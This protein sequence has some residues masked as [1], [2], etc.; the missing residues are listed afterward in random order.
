[1]VLSRSAGAFDLIGR[2]AA[3]GVRGTVKLIE[4]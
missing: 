4:Q 1:M 3:A 2:I